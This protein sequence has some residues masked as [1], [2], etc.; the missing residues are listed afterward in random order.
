[1]LHWLL[2]PIHSSVWCNTGLRSL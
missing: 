1:V 2:L